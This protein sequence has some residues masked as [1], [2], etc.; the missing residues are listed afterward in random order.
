VGR[1]LDQARDIENQARGQR[2]LA[3]RERSESKLKPI[4][5]AC[6]AETLAKLGA[7]VVTVFPYFEDQRLF[8]VEEVGPGLAGEPRNQNV[9]LACPRIKDDDA[10]AVVLKLGKDLHIPDTSNPP[11]EAAEMFTPRTP[12]RFTDREGI[13]SMSALLLRYQGTTVGVMFI[14]FREPRDLAALSE[15]MSV[16]AAA[17]TNP[18]WEYVRAQGSFDAIERGSEA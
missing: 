12:P 14:N 10:P 6:A 5:D 13:K 1:A 15:A 2:V 9:A 4:L 11:P 8:P 17:V 18:L 16:C 3:E 7:D